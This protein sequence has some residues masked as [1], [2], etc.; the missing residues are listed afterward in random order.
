MSIHNCGYIMIVLDMPWKTK[1]DSTIWRWYVFGWYHDTWLLVAA[2]VI[3]QGYKRQRLE[4]NDPAVEFESETCFDFRCVTQPECLMSKKHVKR[5]GFVF[6]EFHEIPSSLLYKTMNEDVSTCTR[7][8]LLQRTDQSHVS[9][10]YNLKGNYVF[11]L[12]DPG[13]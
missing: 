7:F 10:T 4:C 5:S 3:G 2:F 12:S 6:T 8:T 13:F 11:I 9:H 1:L